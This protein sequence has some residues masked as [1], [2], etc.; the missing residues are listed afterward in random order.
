MTV[1]SGIIGFISNTYPNWA[2]TQDYAFPNIT[3]AAAGATGQIKYYNGSSWV[4]KPV[5][6]WNGSS[7]VTKPVK[8]WNGSSWVTTPY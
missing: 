1:K 3:D 4:A 8:R 2:F 7:W 5:K 6:V